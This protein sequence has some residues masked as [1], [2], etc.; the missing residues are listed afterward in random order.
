MLL[1]VFR[2]LSY[3]YM[4][5]AA[6]CLLAYAFSLIHPL[7]TGGPLIPVI[8]IVESL[9][10]FHYVKFSLPFEALDLD[11]LVITSLFFTSG[12]VNW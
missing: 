9:V 7:S 3:Q 10:L 4:E 6:L 12:R 1:V 11:I 2:S 8:G 5:V